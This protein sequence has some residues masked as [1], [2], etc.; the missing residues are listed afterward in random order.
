MSQRRNVMRNNEWLDSNLVLL[1]FHNDRFDISVLGWQ[2]LG[3]DDESV[4]LILLDSNL[5]DPDVASST[6]PAEASPH[7]Y[8]KLTNKHTNGACK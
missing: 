5:D 6:A 1:I 3:V 8:N 4:L 7:E 2:L